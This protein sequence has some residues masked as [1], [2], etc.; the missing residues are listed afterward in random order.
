MADDV[1]VILNGNVHAVSGETYKLAAPD[2]ESF[3]RDVITPFYDVLRKV[4]SFSVDA[5]NSCLPC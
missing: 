4:C 5:S 1:S 2:D 3:L